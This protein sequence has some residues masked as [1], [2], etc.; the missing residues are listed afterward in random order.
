MSGDHPLRILQIEDVPTD[1]ELI[2]HELVMAGFDFEMLCVQ[3]EGEL[4]DALTRFT[5]DIVLSD[6]SL[7]RFSGLQA[8]EIV[9]GH[10]PQV[11]LIFISATIG[12][13]RAVALLRGGATDYVLKSNLSRL[14]PV[15]RRALKEAE[16]REARIHAEAA[17]RENESRFRLLV[18]G[19]KDHALYMLDIDGRIA[20][21]NGA[22]QR[23]YGYAPEQ[24]IGMEMVVLCPKGDAGSAIE[25]VIEA[26]SNGRSESE[27]WRVRADGSLFWANTVTAPLHREGGG[28]VGY[29]QIVRDLSEKRAQEHKIARLNRIYAVLS[30]IN[31]VIVRCKDRTR[32]LEEVCQIA[33]NQGSFAMAWVGLADDAERLHPVAVQGCD[34]S[35]LEQACATL[36]E[37]NIAIQV[38]QSRTPLVRNTLVP[39]PACTLP[40]AI[41]EQMGLRSCA[42][43]PLIVDGRAVGVLEL[44]SREA[45]FF[46]QEE[47]R[48][49]L[50]LIGD[51]WFALEYI[52]KEERLDYLA[53]HDV[54]TGL[55][56]R[57]LCSER[58]TQSMLNLR[59]ESATLALVLLD[60]VRFHFIND[61]L[62]RQAGDVLIRQIAAI[63][64]E[65][66]EEPHF[67]CRLAADCFA[68]VL[69]PIHSEAEAAR[70][71]SEHILPRLAQPFII[72]ND[73]FRLAFKAGI[74]IA[75]TDGGDAETLL[76]NA[77]AALKKSKASTEPYL[78]YLPQMQAHIA[79]RLKLENRLREAL[80][81]GQF[82]LYYQP[83]IELAR[84]NIIGVEA[85]IRWN[86]PEYGLVFPSDFI[87]LL[88]ETGLI[89]E[90]GNWVL[91][92]ALAD[93]RW[94]RE[95]GL[96][97][98]RV[99]VN[100]SAVQLRRDS[101][102][103]T[104]AR[105]VEEC[106]AAQVLDL[107]ITESVVMQDMAA[108]IDKLQR[109]RELGVKVMVDDFGTGYSS[110]SY[111]S[112]L[113]VDALKIDRSFVQMMADS[114]NDLSIVTTVISLAHA[115]GFQVIAEGVETADQAKL[116]HLLRCDQ[117]Q[118][119]L[120]SKAVPLD[121]LLVLMRSSPSW[122]R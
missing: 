86:H 119:F 20:S 4:Y 90:V 54:L 47:M 62:G 73:E 30:G 117:A 104:I 8:L 72:D 38:L 60:V 15:V 65:L 28:L 113:P 101:F 120:Y 27:A 63:L 107:E 97:P 40:A 74:A 92:Q 26:A 45:N 16:E 109:L 78:F 77:E 36:S 50:D 57:L 39:V 51:I 95:Q 68:I 59:H 56:N 9:R 52:S 99:A 122:A 23:L 111:I 43:L 58:L 88:E 66:V 6:Y 115:L 105:L 41:N 93:S 55:P 70:L 96:A 81:N 80:V 64:G 21:W 48:L 75:I 121:Q 89:I 83:K 53:F 25:A 98:A 5:P 114:P 35:M 108:N 49:L 42:A 34:R 13:E 32:L 18:E 82:V 10:L 69:H 76:L 11:P 118:G 91:Q 106:D 3:N 22:A 116:L 24:A 103:D 67:V 12:E 85:L 44:Y 100:V 61:T 71:L 102:V 7:P 1:A 2:R 46:N 84:G 19:L 33:V 110:L 112:R 79:E 31:S 94:L 29:V 14:P 87:P 37:I 17:L